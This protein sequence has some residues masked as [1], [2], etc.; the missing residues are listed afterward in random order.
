MHSAP[1]VGSIGSYGEVVVVGIER[2]ANT[3]FA[4]GQCAAKTV[5]RGAVASD[6]LHARAPDPR[7]RG[8]NA[9]AAGGSVQHDHRAA[10]I[11]AVGTSAIENA[12][13]QVVVVVGIEIASR[14]CPAV[15][16]GFPGCEG[17]TIAVAIEDFRTA[18]VD[19]RHRTVD[20]HDCTG[21][22]HSVD[23]LPTDADGKVVIAIVIEVSDCE[24]VAEIGA[25]LRR[26]GVA[27][28]GLNGGLHFPDAICR[29]TVHHEDF[30]RPGFSADTSILI[31]NCDFVPVISVEIAR[32]HDVTVN[33]HRHGAAKELEQRIAADSEVHP[34]KH[35]KAIAAIF[36]HHQIVDVVA[37]EVA[38]GHAAAEQ[39]T[40]RI[41]IGVFQQNVVVRAQLFASGSGS[42]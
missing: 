4:R 42:G 9:A 14:E 1:A 28:A 40:R 20:H 41:G 3:E 30:A 21:V 6:T 5:G 13:G 39:S 10:A 33:R 8:G 18:G 22:I 11:R 27:A 2:P 19:T 34:A 35:A 31:G 38:R 32:S 12:D 36:R 25:G 15:A 17:Q 29:P 7:V 23:N 24:A 26:S 37:V 16:I